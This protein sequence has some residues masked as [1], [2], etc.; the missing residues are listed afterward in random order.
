MDNFFLIFL[1]ID[2][3]LGI[4][5]FQHSHPFADWSRSPD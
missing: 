1:N 4:L 5:D 3:G 2:P